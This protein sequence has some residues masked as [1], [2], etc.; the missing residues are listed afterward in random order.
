MVSIGTKKQSIH[1]VRY[2]TEE[3]PTRKNSFIDGTDF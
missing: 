3:F 1:R 2:E